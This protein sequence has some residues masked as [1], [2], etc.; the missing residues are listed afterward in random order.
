M[1]GCYWCHILTPALFTCS[2]KDP[3]SHHLLIMR[4]GKISGFW[5][6]KHH[7]TSFSEQQNNHH[8]CISED[9]SVHSTAERPPCAWCSKVIKTEIGGLLPFSHSAVNDLNR[10]LDRMVV[11]AL[12]ILPY[13][14]AL[15]QTLWTLLSEKKLWH[16]QLLL[17]I[18]CQS[19]GQVDWHSLLCH[20]QYVGRIEMWLSKQNK[21]ISWLYIAQ[22][23]TAASTR[24]C[25]FNCTHD[26]QLPSCQQ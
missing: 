1:L 22:A 4:S 21:T 9:L 25:Q 17:T 11:A 14:P 18:C 7:K 19:C 3:N 12:Y 23:A 16:V 13:Q 10:L 5:P 6:F 20:S 24:Q 15:P 26:F 2:V 8:H